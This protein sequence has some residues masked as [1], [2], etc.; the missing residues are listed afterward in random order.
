M[1][2]GMTKSVKFDENG[3]RSEFEIQISALTT[4]GTVQISTWDP[5]YGIKSMP[6]PG[7][8]SSGGDA[9]RNRTFIVLI[10]IVSCDI[11]NNNKSKSVK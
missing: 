10:S 8:T 5:E 1:I 9:L 3:R 6:I 2:D 7:I 11:Y 4:Q